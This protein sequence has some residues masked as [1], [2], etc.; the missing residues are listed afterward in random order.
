M[1]APVMLLGNNNLLSD[2]PSAG[3]TG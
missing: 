1:D 2:K 3:S